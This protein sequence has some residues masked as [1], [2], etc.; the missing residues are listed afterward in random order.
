MRVESSNNKLIINCL[1]RISDYQLVNN[2]S[3]CLDTFTLDMFTFLK[4]TF[5]L[6]FFTLFLPSRSFS[7]L[8]FA[9]ELKEFNLVYY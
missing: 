2:T 3:I 7:P 1:Q 9:C 6:L 5:A 8:A 4:S